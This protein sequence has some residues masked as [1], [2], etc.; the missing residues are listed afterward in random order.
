MP[1]TAMRDHL[2]IVGLLPDY[3]L[4]KLDETSVRRVTR[5]LDGCATCRRELGTAFDVL[6]LIATVSPP[7]AHVRETILQRAAALRPAVIRQD[8]PP[9]SIP[10][11]PPAT[12][13][14][15]QRLDA[16]ADCQRRIPFGQPLP[17]W[18]LVV[19]SVAIFVVSGLL[20]WSFEQRN[21]LIE[22]DR[23]SALINNPAT[24]YPLDDSDLPVAAAG[25]VFA[26]PTGREVYL[27]ANGLPVLPHGQRYQVWLFTTDNTQ[28]SAGL[29]PVEA[30]GEIRALLKTTGPFADYVGVGLTAEPETGSTIPTSDMV[31][32]GS[33]PPEIAALPMLPAMQ[34]PTAGI[35]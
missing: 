14:T 5:H 29:L 13:A 20:V 33:F 32:G 34:I 1:D 7:S 8:A 21:T 11:G 30:D 10:V 15:G 12:G 24:A 28:E 6:G 26:E 25:V 2:T 9:G 3:V 19:A 17:R 4:G 27:V 31:L 16:D 22:D 18:A 35:D 23:I